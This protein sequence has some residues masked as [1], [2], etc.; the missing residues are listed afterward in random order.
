[1]THRGG[2][3]TQG[4]RKLAR[5]KRFELLTSWFV[6]MRQLGRIYLNRRRFPAA[7]CVI[8]QSDA[9]P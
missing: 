1:M 7:R 4:A 2:N 6:G 8:Y 5:P 9:R 3:D